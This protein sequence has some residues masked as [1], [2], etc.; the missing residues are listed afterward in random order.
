VLAVPEV[1]QRFAEIV[2]VPAGPAPAWWEL[3]V[4]GAVALAVAG[5]VAAFAD[6]VTSPKPLRGWLGLETAARVLVV[7]P[8]NATANGLARFDDRVVDGGVRTSAALG[9]AFARVVDSRVEWSVDGLVRGL[10]R[11]FRALG[12]LARR[13]QTGQLHHYYAQ[14]VVALAVLAVLLLVLGQE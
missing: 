14:A 3:L 13:P 4:S 9:T 2:A 10:G 6:R 1:W 11:G 7:R 8:L 5:A 12:R